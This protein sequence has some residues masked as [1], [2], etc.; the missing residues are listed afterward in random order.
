MTEH[1]PMTC[2]C[3]DCY[4]W[5]LC[6]SQGSAWVDTLYEIR[7]LPECAELVYEWGDE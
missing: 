5:R 4:T 2:K 3:R 6:A 7:T 1:D